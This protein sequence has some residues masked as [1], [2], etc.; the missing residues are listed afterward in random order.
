[1]ARR[2]MKSRRRGEGRDGTASKAARRPEAQVP[3]QAQGGISG[4]GW[5]ANGARLDQ[6]VSE[7]LLRHRVRPG[8]AGLKA[9]GGP[10]KAHCWYLVGLAPPVR[11][12]C[13]RWS[14]SRL[15]TLR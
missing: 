15:P 7:L 14:P 9:P 2:G 5:D 12:P 4:D 3:Q 8:P 13:G 1:M 11:C 10:P 6:L